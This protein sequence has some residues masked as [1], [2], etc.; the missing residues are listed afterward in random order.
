M[1]AIRQMMNFLTFFVS[2]FRRTVKQYSPWACSAAAARIKIATAQ[3]RSPSRVPE[4]ALRAPL[5]DFCLSS[6]HSRLHPLWSLIMGPII[7]PATEQHKKSVHGMTGATAFGLSVHCSSE[8][9]S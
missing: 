7:T 8:L 3:R 5:I 4:Q 9:A 6:I 1:Q 2:L